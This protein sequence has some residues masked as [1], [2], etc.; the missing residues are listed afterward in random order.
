MLNPK[1]HGTEHPNSYYVATRQYQATYPQLQSLLDTDICVIGG[2]FSGVNTAIEL[3]QRGYKVVL[4]EAFRVGWG[5]S[6][7]NGGQLIRG[8][9]HGTEQ[10]I[11]D[12]GQEGADAID[13]MGLEA[14]EVVKARIQEFNINCDLKM[15]Y[16]D[17]ANKPRHMEHFRADKAW[18][19]SIGYGYETRLLNKDDMHEVVG[20]DNYIGGLIDMG[21]GHVHPLNLNLGEAEAAAG[22]GVQIFEQSKVLD[23]QQGDRILVKTQEGQVTAN[24]IVI[25]GNAYVAGLNPTLEAKVLPAGSYVIATEPLSPELQ[26][27]VLP[28][29]MAVCDQRVALDYYR[30]SADGRLLFGGLCNYSGRDPASIEATLKPH[31]DKVFPY[32]ANVNIDYQWGGMIG[33]GANRMPQIGRLNPNVYYAQAYSGHGINATHMAA[34]V[35]AEHIHGESDRMEIFER[36]SHMTFPGGRALRSPLLAA[37]MLY[38]RFKDLF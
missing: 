36:I 33:I 9:G 7:R 20:S 29:D 11:N 31:M 8:I 21:S 2:G 34:K 1:T 38:H 23:I 18:L 13:K 3:A 15:G 6:G 25:C 14:V 27:K 32:L 28:Q 17:L 37:G 16:C 35:I 24:K 26:K 22:L 4:L 10:F 19:D 12:I 30:L 5:A